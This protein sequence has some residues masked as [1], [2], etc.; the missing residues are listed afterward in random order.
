MDQEWQYFFIHSSCSYSIPGRLLGFPQDTAVTWA[1]LPEI[2]GPLQMEYL[3]LSRLIQTVCLGWV[4]FVIV[5]ILV[6]I[7]QSIRDL[8]HQNAFEQ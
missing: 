6:T 2:A 3:R 4:D 1:L 8:Q 5:S 7:P